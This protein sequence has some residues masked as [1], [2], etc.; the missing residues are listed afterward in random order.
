MTITVP[1]KF[2]GNVTVEVPDGYLGEQQAAFLARQIALSRVLATTENPDAPDDV[3]F[4]ELE[5]ELYGYEDTPP[6][7]VLEKV[8]DDT[9]VIGVNGYWYQDETYKY[10][11][12]D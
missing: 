3:A 10:D 1:V 5:A 2:E 9:A 8:W 6:V 7:D 12:Q 11:E 4:E